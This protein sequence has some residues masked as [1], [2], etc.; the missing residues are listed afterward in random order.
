MKDSETKLFKKLIKLIEDYSPRKYS[1]VLA[2]PVFGLIFGFFIWNIYLFNFGFLE[3]ELLRAKF[4][5]SGAIFLIVT[6]I[7]VVF[8]ILIYDAIIFLC[9]LS[10][11]F[12]NWSREKLKNAK[13]VDKILLFLSKVPISYFCE[14][15]KILMGQF[16]KREIFYLAYVLLFLFWL[17]FYT[18]YL[19]PIVPALVGGGQPRSISLLATSPNMQVLNSLGIVKGEGADYQTENLCV[20]HE[21]SH[22]VYILRNDRVLMLDRS[23]IHGFGSLP[24]KKSIYEQDCIQYARSWSLQGYQVSKLLFITSITNLVRQL[25]GLSQIRFDIPQL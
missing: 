17:V 5:L 11:K 19:F 23:L 2:L 13:R 1:I 24:G 9:K 18:I 25:F 20:V 14:K 15:A 12:L 16:L 4:I 7:I 21:N 22:S 3:E 8:F 10:W 6:S